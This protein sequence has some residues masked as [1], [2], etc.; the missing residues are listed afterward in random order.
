M[1]P[2]RVIW[3]E[4]WSEIVMV[5]RSDNHMD[6]CSDG[7]KKDVAWSNGWFRGQEL[8]GSDTWWDWW[9]AGFSEVLKPRFL[10][11]AY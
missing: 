4:F 2:I 10:A 9:V 3:K 8:C 6:F 11:H 7:H 5:R 1:D